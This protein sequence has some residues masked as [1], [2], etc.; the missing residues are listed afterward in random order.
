MLLF[1]YFNK[2]IL[3]PIYIVYNGETYILVEKFI[4]TYIKILTFFWIE[5]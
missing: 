1:L 3:N 2:G 4:N 5:N